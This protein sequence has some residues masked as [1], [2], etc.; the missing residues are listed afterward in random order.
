MKENSRVARRKQQQSH[1]KRSK[2]K[3]FMKRVFLFFFILFVL[4]SLFVL[5]LW[6]EHKDLIQEVMNNAK[7]KVAQI[8]TSDF[9]S[10][11]E[12]IIYDKNGKEIQR[13]SEKD[14]EYL[15]IEDAQENIKNAFVAIEDERF[16]E[17]EGVDKK[18]LLRVMY[19]LIKN[20]GE[21]T[22]GGSTITQQ[23]VKN[24]YLTHDRL[25]TRK[26]EEMIIALELEKKYTKDEILEFYINNIN[27]SNGNFGF[28]TA[29]LYYFSKPSNELTLSEIAFLVGVPNNPSLYDPIHNYDN[30]VKRRNIIL[31]KMKELMM[32][33]EVEYK[34]AIEEKITLNIAKKEKHVESYAINYAVADATKIIMKENGFEFRY[35][36]NSDEERAVYEKEY[37]DLFQ[38]V[39]RQIRRGGYKI[40]TT[41]DLEKQKM[42]Q[43]S[44]DQEL[45]GFTKTNADTGRYLTQGAG[46]LIEN[47]T[48]HVLAMVGGRSQE[49]IEDWF[50]RGY[51]AYRQPGSA[52]K[53]IVAYTPAFDRGMIAST[54]KADKDDPKDKYYPRNVQRKHYGSVTL[55][56]AT[57]LSLN[58]IPYQLVKEFTPKESLNYL[59]EM[60]FSKLVDGD[61]QAGISIGGFTHGVTPLEMAGAF[62][63]LARNGLY[64]TPTAITKITTS[65]DEPVYERTIHAKR[66][67]DEDSAYIMTDI[68]VGTL[69]SRHGSGYGLNVPNMPTAGKTGTTNDSKDG[70]MAGYTPYY[71][72]VVWVG[73]DMP[74]PINGL[75]G[76]TYPGR[77][78]HDFMVKVHQGLPTKE[79]VVPSTLQQLYVNPSNGNVT[80]EERKGWTKEW[81]SRTYLEFHKWEDPISKEEKEEIVEKP[82]TIIEEPIETPVEEIDSMKPEEKVETPKETQPEESK[83]EIT[84]PTLPQK[85]EE[86]EPKEQEPEEPSSPSTPPEESGQVIVETPS[87]QDGMNE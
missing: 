76:S 17:H 71:T 56:Y 82:I 11:L 7:E 46:V 63:T 79:F 58:T 29:S 77:A 52:I 83:P 5:S 44:I 60:E 16:Y 35:D 41:L 43:E 19:L 86:S 73:N 33:S 70:W 24:M 74:T 2:L 27:F 80:D 23:L 87:E 53:P 26:L 75:Y 37:N 55:R 85:P 61:N 49:G 28:E 66:I 57:E 62:S 54:K 3:R 72:A 68:L 20:K 42:L 48:G 39:N 30:A 31:G 38:Q 9:H 84:L 32:I 4:G 6:F 12:T 14:Y 81:V 21:I 18:A 51:L 67:Y 10:R 8:E 34:Q 15:S 78:W 22:Q 13:L 45:K 40:Y 59:Q 1:K 36:F 69:Q 50:N 64:L 65:T 47:E 25:F